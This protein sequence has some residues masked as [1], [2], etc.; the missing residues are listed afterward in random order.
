MENYKLSTELEI[1]QIRTILLQKYNNP[2]TELVYKNLYE[3]IVSVILSAQCTDKRVNL[4]TPKLF[5]EYPKI[6]DLANANLDSVKELIK[7]CSYFNNKAKNIIEMAKSVI[8]S[9]GG[10]I[11]LEQK[12]L[13]KLAGVGIKTANV[14]LIEYDNRNLMAVD[15]HVFRVSH[16]LGLTKAK[17]VKDTQNDLSEKF[18]SDLANL[19]QAFVLFGRYICKAKNPS[20]NDCFLVEFCKSKGSFK[21]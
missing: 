8:N 3:L 1:E 21:A 17:N 15:T 14:V 9:Y 7:S 10:K 13:I 18:K 16:R 20:C 6:E 2:K 12:E 11:P 19:H 5:K 4:I